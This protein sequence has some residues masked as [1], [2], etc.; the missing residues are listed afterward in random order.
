MKEYFFKDNIYLHLK[1]SGTD[2]TAGLPLEPSNVWLTM[3]VAPVTVFGEFGV[4][5][6]VLPLYPLTHVMPPHK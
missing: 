3:H 6:Q 1:F 5:V 4:M 2:L